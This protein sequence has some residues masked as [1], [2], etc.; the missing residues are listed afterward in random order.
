[1]EQK[2]NMVGTTRIIKEKGVTLQ[3]IN[4]KLNVFTILQ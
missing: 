2:D 1:M 4:E 3:I